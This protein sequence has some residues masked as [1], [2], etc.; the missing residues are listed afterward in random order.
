M[1]GTFHWRAGTTNGYECKPCGNIVCHAPADQAY[2]T[3]TC[4]PATKGF[5]CADQPTCGPDQYLAGATVQGLGTCTDQPTCPPGQRLSGA[6]VAERGVCTTCPD[7]AFL[8]AATG[9][10]T[11]CGSSPN[12]TCAGG[13]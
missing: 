13:Q 2:R 8:E 9:M 5:K 3:G 1:K 10:C 6:A 11:A 7:G 12:A 4:T